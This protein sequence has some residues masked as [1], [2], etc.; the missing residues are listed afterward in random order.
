M[1][2][3]FSRATRKAAIQIMGLGKYV[4]ALP[5]QAGGRKTLILT[6]QTQ[7]MSKYAQKSTLIPWAISNTLK[8][9]SKVLST[10]QL[11]SA[12]SQAVGTTLYLN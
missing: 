11:K 8:N 7:P 10:S 1:L 6:F 9:K 4:S 2:F 5:S 12:F 3:S